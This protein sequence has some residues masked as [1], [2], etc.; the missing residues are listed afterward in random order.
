MNGNH[1]A[2]LSTLE[3]PS[4]KMRSHVWL[5]R[6]K[7]IFDLVCQRMS[8][9]IFRSEWTSDFPKLEYKKTCTNLPDPER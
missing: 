3:G 8:R 6:P 9:N 7:N 2:A 4:G 1:L 5:W